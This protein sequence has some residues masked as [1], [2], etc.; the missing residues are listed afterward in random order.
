MLHTLVYCQSLENLQLIQ[1][2]SGKHTRVRDGLDSVRG[3]CWR[4]GSQTKEADRDGPEEV[5]AQQAV[6]GA[7]HN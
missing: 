2:E 5:A 4:R 1:R 6:Q 3:R 7:D